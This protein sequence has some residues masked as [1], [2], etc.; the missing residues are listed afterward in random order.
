MLVEE[1]CEGNFC[2][3]KNIKI[4]Q[5]QAFMNSSKNCK[6]GIA[7]SLKVS[8]SILYFLPPEYL[9][10]FLSYSFSMQPFS[11]P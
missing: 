9:E 6:L 11:T 10:I 7:F 3:C 2:E 5:E 1:T 4:L 8:S